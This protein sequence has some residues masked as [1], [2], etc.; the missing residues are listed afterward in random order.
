MTEDTNG[1]VAVSSYEAQGGEYMVGVIPGSL[2]HSNATSTHIDSHRHG[3][4]LTSAS[5]I[6]KGAV[7]I[8]AC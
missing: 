6:E 1:V 3:N 4:A 8:C 5:D 7:V 2:L